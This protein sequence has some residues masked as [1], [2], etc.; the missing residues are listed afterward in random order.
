MFNIQN[1]CL[2]W[3]FR[4]MND[5]LSICQVPQVSDISAVSLTVKRYVWWFY[6]T[7]F[8]DNHVSKVLTLKYPWLYSL[9]FLVTLNHLD[10][11]TEKSLLDSRFVVEKSAVFELC[12]VKL[13][14]FSILTQLLLLLAASNSSSCTCNDHLNF[15]RILHIFKKARHLTGQRV[16]QAHLNILSANVYENNK[17][18]I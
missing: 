18:C 5:Y 10:L 4:N 11:L 12:E 6:L 9:D 16:W 8:V 14:N 1:A 2:D 15:N 17:I 3:K 13:Y 7:T